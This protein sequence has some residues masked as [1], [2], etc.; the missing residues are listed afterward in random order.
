[1]TALREL[2]EANEEVMTRIDTVKRIKHT[3]NY[4]KRIK[5]LGAAQ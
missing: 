5:A 2:R 3:A 1:M 4:S